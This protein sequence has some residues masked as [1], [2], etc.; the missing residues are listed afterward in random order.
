MRVFWK[1]SIA[2]PIRSTISTAAKK[3][4]TEESYSRAL[5]F[6]LAFIFDMH[7][8]LKFLYLKV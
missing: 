5:L 7:S 4:H 6:L 8:Y 2:D 3:L 1:K